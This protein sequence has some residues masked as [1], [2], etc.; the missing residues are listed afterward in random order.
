MRFCM[1]PPSAVRGSL[2]TPEVTIVPKCSQEIV[3]AIFRNMEKIVFDLLNN[4]SFE[5]ELNSYVN[6]PKGADA[7]DNLLYYSAKQYTPAEF[8]IYNYLVDRACQVYQSTLADKQK[9][10]I[11]IVVKNMLQAKVGEQNFDTP[12]L[13]CQQIQT[14]YAG[15]IQDV[16][17]Q[18]KYLTTCPLYHRQLIYS[19]KVL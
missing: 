19:E 14:Q 18:L 5:D 4:P 3:D 13:A 17:E 7:I 6:C 15:P 12:Q 8:C 16:V 9:Y 2:C 11:P 10:F 1:Q